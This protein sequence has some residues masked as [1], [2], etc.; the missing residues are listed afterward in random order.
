LDPDILAAVQDSGLHASSFV[1]SSPSTSV[2]RKSRP[3]K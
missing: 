2:K 3:W 1:T